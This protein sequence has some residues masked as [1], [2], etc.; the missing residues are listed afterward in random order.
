MLAHGHDFIYTNSS[1]GINVLMLIKIRPFS[2]SAY[3][4]QV[5]CSAESKIA[6]LH[7]GAGSAALGNTTVLSRYLSRYLEPPTFF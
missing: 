5:M 6:E 2:S 3:T 7:G 1:I 4:H